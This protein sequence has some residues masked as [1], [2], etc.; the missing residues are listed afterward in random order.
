MSI[1]TDLHRPSKHWL[2]RHC[3]CMN[4]EGGSSWWTDAREFCWVVILLNWL[5]I[6]ISAMRSSKALQVTMFSGGRLLPRADESPLTRWGETQHCYMSSCLDY[7][8]V[9][10]NQCYK[11]IQAVDLKREFK[12][13]TEMKNCLIEIVCSKGSGWRRG[14]KHRLKEHTP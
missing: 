7:E 12:L 5:I 4:P 8:N 9:L 14:R 11:F 13:L 1:S 6:S 10:L 3:F 2:T